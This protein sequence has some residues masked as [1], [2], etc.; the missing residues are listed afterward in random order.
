[1]AKFATNA[2]CAM[3]LLN[4]IQ[5]TE[6]ISGSVV[7]L[8]M[9]KRQVH[10]QGHNSVSPHKRTSNSSAIQGP[11]E[12]PFE[13]EELTMDKHGRCSRM[14][15]A[16]KVQQLLYHKPLSLP[17]QQLFITKMDQLH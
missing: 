1:M 9:F 6:S 17:G 13:V 7:P 3:L 15:R 16:C 12:L 11:T 8:A 5:V 4:L 2:R 10:F 14:Q